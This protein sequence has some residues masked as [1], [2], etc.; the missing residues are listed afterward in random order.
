MLSGKYGDQTYYI[1]HLV[2]YWL[3]VLRLVRL[4]VR[5]LVHGLVVVAG[6]V[7]AVPT[8]VPAYLLFSNKGLKF[9]F[10]VLLIVCGSDISE[11]QPLTKI[12]QL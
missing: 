10:L 3:V 8:P 5:L 6:T 9:P 11:A 4:L 1:A 7:N 12:Q 2:L